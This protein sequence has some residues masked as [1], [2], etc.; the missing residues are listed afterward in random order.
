MEIRDFVAHRSFT[1]NGLWQWDEKL[2]LSGPAETKIWLDRL[3]VA[4]MKRFTVLGYIK[5]PFDTKESIA[6]RGAMKSEFRLGRD[7]LWT[8][9]DSSSILGFI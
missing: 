4:T 6:M 1:G 9:I 2:R 7:H 3:L 8:K 5:K